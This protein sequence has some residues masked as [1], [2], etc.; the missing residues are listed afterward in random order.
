MK[1]IMTYLAGTVLAVALGAFAAAAEDITVEVSG[2]AET[3]D[4]VSYTISETDLAGAQLK[5]DASITVSYN[6]DD[7]DSCPVKLVF[8]YWDKSAADKNGGAGEP[9]SFEVPAGSF[10]G[11]KAEFSFV[12][13]LKV[14]K[15]DDLSPVYAIDVAAA[16]GTAVTCTGVEAKGVW[17]KAD[18]ASKNL[19][20][21]VCVDT[22]SAKESTNWGQ[23]LSVHFDQF[24]SLRLTTD[25]KIVA[26]FESQ[27]TKDASVCPVELIIQSADD[28]ISPKSRNGHAWEKVPAIA[29]SDSFA[30]FD[31]A[32][33]IKAY[34]T[35][36][37]RCI[38][39]LHIGDAG[40]GTIKCTGFY[41]LDCAT[42]IPKE[43][44]PVED[45]S[46]VETKPAETTAP[47]PE[48]T[49][50]AAAATE[51]VES[52]ADSSEKSGANG[53]IFIIIGVVAGV[54]L[55]VAVLFI[56]LGRKSKE[57][58]DVQRHRFVKKK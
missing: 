17:S 18:L 31:Y 33:F 49:A 11:G 29:F 55:A 47:A 3:S 44:T 54:G 51:S 52:K 35:T 26:F 37:F 41:V 13:I 46:V 56:I 2:A 53:I 15:K 43:E 20:S 24:D 30:V 10:E 48:T 1:R 39:T 21:T 7:S 8:R 28:T 50:A 38:S 25:S 34:G 9:S 36:D 14:F 19:Y 12:D 57:T 4:G 40:R 16:N 58:Y 23:S 5:S 42:I 6:G 32:G 27:L 45:S 22:S